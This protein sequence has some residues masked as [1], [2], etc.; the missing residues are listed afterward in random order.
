[1]LASPVEFEGLDERLK[2]F[3]VPGVEGLEGLEV[4]K[5]ARPLRPVATAWALRARAQ[6]HVLDFERRV[7][8]CA[9]AEPG[10]GTNVGELRALQHAL[11][12]G[13]RRR[14]KVLEWAHEAWAREVNRVLG[15][16]R[17]ARARGAR[18]GAA[19]ALLMACLLGGL[20][21]CALGDLPKPLGP[22]TLKLV[23]PGQYEL[24]LT[25]PGAQAHRAAQLLSA[26]AAQ[27]ERL[28]SCA[29][30]G[31]TAEETAP[32]KPQSPPPPDAEPPPPL[33]T[34]VTGTLLC[35]AVGG[36]S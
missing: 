33:V 5:L 3:L 6:L 1:M 21:G 7:E 32:P 11:A 10:A 31:V 27:E 20:G 29:A 35:S 13:L 25:F 19:L 30:S 12:L 2:R 9:V 36:A 15:Q 34:T 23:A 28:G 4:V 17:R 14:Q 8:R 16:G 22:H 24:R 18:R 26:H